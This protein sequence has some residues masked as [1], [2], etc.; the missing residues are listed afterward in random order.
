[1]DLDKIEQQLIRD[2]G[3][4]LKP[5]K[6]SVG[7]LTI[8]IG[9]NLDDNGIRETEARFMLRNDVN[10]TINECRTLSFFQHLNEPRQAVLIN[11][12][13]N[14]GLARVRG[15]KKMLAALEHLDYTAAAIEMMDSLWAKQ[16]GPR[17]VRLKEQMIKGE[18]VQ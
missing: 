7:K 15:F 6:D 10:Q 12:V 8:G 2:E 14:I 1:M 9:R 16:V 11:L 4:R 3:L 13:F 17:A 5:Y 18:W